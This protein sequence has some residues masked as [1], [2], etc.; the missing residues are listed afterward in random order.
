VPLLAQ[1]VCIGVLS[2]AEARHDRFTTDDEQWMTLLAALCAP[3]IEVARLSRLAQLDSLTG[4][5]NRH[6][7]DLA[8]AGA[9]HD[10]SRPLSVAMCDIDRFKDVNDRDGHAT[11]DLVLK[12]VALVLTSVLRAG[13]SVVRYG[14]EEFLLV[15]PGIEAT[16]AARVAERARATIETEPLAALGSTHPVTISLGVAER[17]GAEVR[18]QLIARADEALYRAKRMGRNQVCLAD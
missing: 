16:K 10:P 7:L 2:V 17:H 8:F 6:G 4:V 18:E 1:D 5:L 12:R 3:H 13:D 14:G 15:L 9:L 11:G